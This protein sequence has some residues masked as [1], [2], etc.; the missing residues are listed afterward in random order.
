MPH[1]RS[2]F[3]L[4]SAVALGL[5]GCA[6]QQEVTAPTQ[7]TVISRNDTGIDVAQRALASL[8][9]NISQPAHYQ[10]V[11]IDTA[12]P[13][14]RSLQTITLADAVN[15]SVLASSDLKVK[16]LAKIDPASLNWIVMEKGFPRPKE[17]EGVGG[18]DT[19]PNNFSEVNFATNKTEILNRP[20]LDKLVALAS[21]VSGV[22]Y[23]V[24]YSDETGIEAGN[25]TLSKDRSKVVFD[26]LVAAGVNASRITESGA[27]IS[28]AYPT[29]DANRRASITF[30]VVRNQ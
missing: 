19:Q 15:S 18:A 28:R 16:P 11:Y 7:A 26:Y 25:L 12:D 14:H 5:T 10:H 30:N 22:F 17:M 9:D 23:V 29:L 2:R 27:G 3:M 21:R 13:A 1:I 24:G 8:T 4:C 20:K 6:T